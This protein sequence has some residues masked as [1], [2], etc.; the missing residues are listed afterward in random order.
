ME[1]L[2]GSCTEKKDEPHARS[3]ATPK[4]RP[5]GRPSDYLPGRARNLHGQFQRR[6]IGANDAE[7]QMLQAR[8]AA[9]HEAV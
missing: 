6:P 2:I 9:G 4:A 5:P 1:F 7:W 3:A 8:A